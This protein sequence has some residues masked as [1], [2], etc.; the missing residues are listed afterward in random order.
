MPTLPLTLAMALFVTP[1]LA[2]DDLGTL[3]DSIPD[4]D[5]AKQEE[6]EGVEPPSSLDEDLGQIPLPEYIGQVEAHLLQAFKLPKGLAKKNAG[7]SLQ[8]MVKITSSGKVSELRAVALSGNKKL[9]KI[10]VASV[11][12]AQPLPIPPIVLRSQ[13]LRG[14]VVTLPV[15]AP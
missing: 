8:F 7:A 3:L 12:A 10:A 9:D 15:A 1:A 6:E 2:D 4:I 5:T 14:V 13:A 11:K